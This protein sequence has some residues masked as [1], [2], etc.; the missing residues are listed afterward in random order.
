MRYFFTKILDAMFP[1]NKMKL[2]NHTFFL[3]II[4]GG[5]AS[6]TIGFECPMQVLKNVG[7]NFVIEVLHLVEICY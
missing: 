7:Y 3:Q 5:Q 2:I 1:T 4:L 6:G